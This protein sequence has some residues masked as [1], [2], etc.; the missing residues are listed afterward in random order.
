[1]TKR[2]EPS[3]LDLAQRIFESGGWYSAL[4]LEKALMSRYGVGTT[5]APA[6]I[7]DLRKR[8]LKF[9]KRKNEEGFYEFRL[10]CPEGVD[11]GATGVACKVHQGE[12]DAHKGPTPSPSRCPS[13]GRAQGLCWCKG[14]QEAPKGQGG[15]L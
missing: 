7:C 2:K 6:M 10:I 12:V 11:K 3:K 1:M 15:L 13:C 8:G 14:E 4:D 9:S 5:A